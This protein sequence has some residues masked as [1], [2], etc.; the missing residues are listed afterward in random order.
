[1][2]VNA[3]NHADF[4]PEIW[5]AQALGYLKAN[6]VMLNLVNRDYS[7]EVATDGDT[8]NVPIRGNLTVRT[9]TAGGTVSSDSPTGDKKAITMSHKYISFIVEDVAEAQSRPD[10]MNGYIADGMAMIA[11]DI[12][13]SL[14]ALYSG[15]SATPID[16]TSGVGVDDMTEARRLLNAAKVPQ[17]GRSIV[18]HE[19]AEAEVLQ[20]AQF[21]NAQNDPANATA[22]Q[23][24]TLGRKYGFGHYMDQQ[25]VVAGGECK[26]LAFHRDA[27][28]L[29][30]RRLPDPPANTGVRAATMSEDG[31]GLRV[32]WGY[33]MEYLGI[34]VVIDL[35]YGAAELRD[36]H[37]V[38][39]RSSE[40][41]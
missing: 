39:I 19:D 35:I 34:Q 23:L 13:A 22:L 1:M 30:T 16:A 6:T 37:A 9:K 32:L 14:L 15:F 21:T 20:L 36:N 29:V 26:N 28:A 31:L 7:D 17:Q 11:E 18:W 38:V 4:I 5:A 33:S 24:A 40:A 2:T 41:A 25:V 27:M 8:I 3:T 10:I 12:D